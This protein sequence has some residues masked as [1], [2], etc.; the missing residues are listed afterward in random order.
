[1]I[2]LI[3]GHTPYINWSSYVGWTFFLPDNSLTHSKDRQHET[4]RWIYSVHSS[5][6][7][8]VRSQVYMVRL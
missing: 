5:E 7:V 4:Y 1:L 8:G 6:W 2:T 3:N